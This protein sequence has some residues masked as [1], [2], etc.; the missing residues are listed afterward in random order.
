VRDHR[1]HAGIILFPSD[2]IHRRQRTRLHHGKR[3]AGGKARSG[4]TV[5]EFL[6]KAG[7]FGLHRVI[8]LARQIADIHFG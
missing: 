8:G 7:I 3:F 2:A 4:G 5:L 1:Y 6:Q